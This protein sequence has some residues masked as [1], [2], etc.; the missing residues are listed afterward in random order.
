[1][2]VNMNVYVKKNLL[3]VSQLD[4]IVNDAIYMRVLRSFLICANYRNYVIRVL[5]LYLLLMI[6]NDVI[7]R[8]V[9]K[10]VLKLNCY[11]IN[12]W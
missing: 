2:L 4:P 3:C 9:R 10:E 1:M 6:A 8:K 5:N 12:V 11:S 7:H